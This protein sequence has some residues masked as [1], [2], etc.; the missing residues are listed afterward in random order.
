MISAAS[1]GTTI[2]TTILLLD[3]RYNLLNHR[4]HATCDKLTMMDDTLSIQY[5][6]HPPIYQLCLVFGQENSI[7]HHHQ[8]FPVSA[9]S[10]KS[11]RI[12]VCRFFVDGI[13]QGRIFNLLPT[14]LASLY[15]V[16]DMGQDQAKK[17]NNKITGCH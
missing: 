11:R 5:L 1:V 16:F 8:Q 9:R 13:P 10:Q 6:R 4:N 15:S 14:C 7:P 17:T 12:V 3:P 2:L